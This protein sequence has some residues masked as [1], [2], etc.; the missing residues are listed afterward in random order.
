MI[1][2]MEK[3]LES[4]RSVREGDK[5]K[6]REREKMKERG[7]GES[8]VTFLPPFLLIQVQQINLAGSKRRE[9]LI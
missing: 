5:M 8:S 3:A 9:K 2:G 7:R 1:D 6:E 4:R